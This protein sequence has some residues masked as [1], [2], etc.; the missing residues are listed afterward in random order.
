MRRLAPEERALWDRVGASVRRAGQVAQAR[1]P[2]PTAFV[3]SLPPPP[4]GA[5]RRPGVGQT[6]DAGWDRRLVGGRVVPDRTIDLH[7]LTAEH[8]HRLLE[9]T[10][11]QALAGGERVLLVITGKARGEPGARARPGTRGII[12]ASIGDWLDAS[13]WS[14]RIAAVRPAA[15]RHGGAGALYVILR[16]ARG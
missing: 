16:R 12:R 5:K 11:G 4:S 8:A 7:G 3:P 15:I 1:P 9:A 2:L 14:D 6:L 13:S 10:I